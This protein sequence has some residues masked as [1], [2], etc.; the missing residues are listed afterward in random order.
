MTLLH[1]SWDISP[2]PAN[3]HPLPLV[4]FVANHHQIPHPLLKLPSDWTLLQTLAL[5]PL[6]PVLQVSLRETESCLHFPTSLETGPASLTSRQS[7]L[8]PQT[9]HVRF[10]ALRSPPQAYRR[11][12][13]HCRPGPGGT[14]NSASVPQPNGQAFQLCL[15]GIGSAETSMIVSEGC[16]GR[17][18]EDR[19]GC[20]DLLGL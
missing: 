4:H 11:P 18:C 3:D 1:C 20:H 7:R 12:S 13:H 8:W 17:L 15:A 5:K 16:Q 9:V 10:A 2:P 6:A 19:P 14:S